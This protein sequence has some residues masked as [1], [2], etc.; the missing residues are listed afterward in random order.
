M[1]SDIKYYI[2]A[3]WQFVKRPVD[4]RIKLSKGT[5]KAV[6]AMMVVDLLVLVPF[7]ALMSAIME[8]YGI[9]MDEH[10][11]ARL[12][13]ESP[14]TVLVA[15]VVFAPLLEEFAFRFFITLQRAYYF[16]LPYLMLSSLSDKSRFGQQRGMVKT[17]RW[18]FPII[19]YLSCLLFGIV[20]IYNFPNADELMAVAPLLTFPQFFLGTILG[21]LRVRFGFWYNVLFHA[22]HNAALIVPV[23]VFG[24]EA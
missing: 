10:E 7:I 12:L 4:G 2:Q 22:I 21:F 23:I 15:A 20:H 17:W 18:L 16:T 14:M 19:F 3:W 11:V 24:L 9:N 13:R 5:Y 8:S 6:L 1:I